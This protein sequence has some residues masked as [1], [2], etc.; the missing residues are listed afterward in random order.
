MN[1][2]QPEDMPKS[3][4]YFQIPGKVLHLDGDQLYLKKCLDLYEKI[5]IPVTGIHCKRG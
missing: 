1:L 2:N 5:G 4:N 3:Y